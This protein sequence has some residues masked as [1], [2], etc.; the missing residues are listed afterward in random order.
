MG[1]RKPTPAPA[2]LDCQHL[3]AKVASHERQQRQQAAELRKLQAQ[4]EAQAAELA[5]ERERSRRLDEALSYVRFT[6]PYLLH[7][8]SQ[9]LPVG[10]DLAAGVLH[11]N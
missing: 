8:F 10:N 1:A 11:F 7:Q 2:C 3:L 5:E 6:Q 9:H 4:L